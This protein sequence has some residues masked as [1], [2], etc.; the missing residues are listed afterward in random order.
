MVKPALL[1]IM[2][3]LTEDL[4]K[5]SIYQNNC[6]KTY[7]LN[8][9]TDICSLNLKNPIEYNLTVL[10]NLF[11]DLHT[12][13]YKEVTRNLFNIISRTNK[14]NYTRKVFKSFIKAKKK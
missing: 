10:T 14:T 2:A 3:P 12:S 1:N 6:Q 11:E 5:K 4:K 7:E 9:I 8:I 13:T